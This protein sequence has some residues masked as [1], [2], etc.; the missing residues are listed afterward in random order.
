MITVEEA[1]RIMMTKVPITDGFVLDIEQAVGHWCAQD[2]HARHDHPL[3]DM[4]AVD[5]FAVN[6]NGPRWSVIDAIPA[7]KF[8]DRALA[9]GQC[10]RIFTGA[11]VPEGTTTIVMQEHGTHEDGIF[12]CDKVLPVAG[13]NIRRGGESFKVGDVLLGKGER[14]EPAAVGLL[15]SAGEPGILVHEPPVVGVVRTGGEFNE[16]EEP[17]PGRIF[18]S[19]DHMVLAALHAEGVYDDNLFTCTDLREDIMDAL[20][21]ARDSS[22]VILTTGGV[23]V[24]DHDLVEDVLVELGAV[25][26]FHGVAQKPGKP[27]L[28][29]MLGGTPVFGLPGNPRAVM[30]CFW[31]YVLPFL[32]AMQGAK[33]PWLKRDLLPIGHEVN[34]KGE[35]AEFRAAKVKGGKATLLADEGSHMLRSL[36]DADA[37]AYIPAEVRA[38][39]EG[40]PIEVHYLPR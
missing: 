37:L 19:N 7:G 33:E 31:E 36:V 5:G 1:K 26:H 11:A 9:S 16:G 34:V 30:V 25:V 35:R 22:D 8:M 23:S 24:G 6:G 10:V 2:V 20:E 4:C 40:D 28:F 27:M 21:D 12:R 38:L 17:E 3:F 18:S 14:I 13:A 29:A 39:R 15:A 32:R